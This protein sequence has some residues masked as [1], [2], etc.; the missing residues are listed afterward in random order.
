MVIPLKKPHGAKLILGGV[1]DTIYKGKD[2]EVNGWGKFYLPNEVKMKVIGVIDGT[3]CPSEQLVLMICEDGALYAY[4][5]EELHAVALNLGQLLDEGIEYPAA[6]S[7]YKGE[8]FK[9][10]V[11]SY[12]L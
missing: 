3:S 10:M 1:D 4:D 6:K 2:A 5:G 11:R 12:S 7:Y 9:D 8:T